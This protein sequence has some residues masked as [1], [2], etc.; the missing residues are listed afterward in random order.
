MYW[1][2][3]SRYLVRLQPVLWGKYHLNYS[4]A[5]L[6]RAGVGVG[7]TRLQIDINGTLA[8]VNLTPVCREVSIGS[9]SSNQFISTVINVT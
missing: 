5:E 6:G 8:G 9:Y 4:W 3:I 2:V 1:C 7:G